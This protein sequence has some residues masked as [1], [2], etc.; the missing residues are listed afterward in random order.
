LKKAAVI[1]FMATYC[2]AADNTLNLISS[3]ARLCGVRTKYNVLQSNDLHSEQIPK[4]RVFDIL[5]HFRDVL[6][7]ETTQP[8]RIQDIAVGQLGMV[9]P[10]IVYIHTWF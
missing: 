4:H 2:S 10:E 6:R 7:L 9:N 8:Q 1:V 3:S 5:V